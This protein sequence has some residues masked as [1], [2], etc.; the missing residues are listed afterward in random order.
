MTYAPVIAVENA[1]LTRVKEGGAS[2]DWDT[3]AGAGAER[4]SGEVG[5]Y[6]GEQ[7]LTEVD[8]ED[9]NE[10]GQAR[11]I[12]PL[13]AAVDVDRNDT[14]TFEHDGDE[15]TRRARNVTRLELAGA[16]VV[17]FWDE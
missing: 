7:L 13:E 2:Q 11:L 4:W 8:G 10:V 3:P 15:L 6:F 16:V 9:L 17:T 5:A 14:L 1:T 12:F